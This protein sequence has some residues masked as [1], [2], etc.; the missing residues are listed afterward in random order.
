MATRISDAVGAPV[1]RQVNLQVL[2]RIEKLPS[3]SSV[4]S[5]F[6][7]LCREEFVSARDFEKVIAKDQALV[8][9]LLRVA[10]SGMYGKSRSIRSIAEAVVLVGLANMTKIVY[11]V[12]TEGLTRNRLLNYAY[13]PSRG[14]WMHTTAVGLAARAVA[15]AIP[16]RRMH[17]EEAFVAG[18]LHD[19]GKLI[20]DD[21]LDRAPGKRHVTP[22]EEVEAVGLDHA[23]LAEYILKQ[24]KLPPT[25]IEAVRFHHH[26]E[27]ALDD[28]TGAR[29][30]A[31]SQHIVQ[32]WRVGYHDTIDLELEFDRERAGDLVA[33]LKIPNAK[34]E[35]ILWDVRQSLAGIEKL[36]PSD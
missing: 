14:F 35:Q 13:E 18:L 31:L 8:A 5:E 28:P 3:L 16:D 4:V 24:W 29:I 27:Q 12:S 17:P 2:E 23:E 33:R 10:N 22:A 11:A 19:V 7:R 6:L 25:I 32:T 20:V 21:F 34:L 15:E 26:P 1:W 36:Y 30:L 9:R